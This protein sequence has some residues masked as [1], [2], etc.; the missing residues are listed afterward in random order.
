[1]ARAVQDGSLRR[2]FQGFTDDQASVL[3]GLGASAISMM[4][5]IIW[6][7]EKNAG[8]Y[9][10]LLSQDHLPANGGLFRSADDQ[11]RGAVIEGLLCR[12][13]AKLDADLTNEVL[14]RLLPFIDRELAELDH[15]TLRLLPEALPYAR[16]IAALFDPYR[17]DSVRRFSSAV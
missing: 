16:T 6:Q 13:E 2:N 17:Q 14:T 1:M 5:D 12:G 10:M 11:R 8:R 4:P 7:N 9:R 15:G 3:V